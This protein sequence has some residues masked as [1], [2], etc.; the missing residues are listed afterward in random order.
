M[1]NLIKFVKGDKTP[2]LINPDFIQEVSGGDAG[3]I[4]VVKREGADGQ[5][6][7]HQIPIPVS[8]AIQMIEDAKS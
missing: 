6:V 5:F 8:T 3:T 4:I 2:V 1:S 7:K